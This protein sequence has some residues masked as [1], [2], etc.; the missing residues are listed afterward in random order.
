MNIKILF[1]IIFCF[2]VPGPLLDPLCALA[3]EQGISL[4]TQ[5]DNKEATLEMQGVSRPI[6]DAELSFSVA[7]AVVDIPVKQGQMVKKGTLLMSLDT[8][9]EDSRIAQ[10]DEEL[11]SNIK[12]RIL[13][14][15]IAQAKLDKNRFEQALRSNAATLMEV[16]HARL[17]LALSVLSLE[18]EQFRLKQL[19]HTRVELAAYRNKMTLH[20]VCDG[21][22]EDVFVEKGMSV[23]SNIKAI[24]FVAI[25]PLLVE[26]TLPIEVASRLKAGDKVDVFLPRN[27]A[28]HHDEENKLVGEIVQVA[29]IGVLSNRTLKVRIHVPNPEGIPAGLMVRVRFASN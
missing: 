2:F 4:N 3:N 12:L 7:G 27:I 26:L 29:K 16:Q 14:A 1:L 17:G 6:Y 28:T 10:I 18:E 20:A 21:I 22:V 19:K 23:G 13:E 15:R 8:Q 11:N 9:V 5:T 24:R 25:D